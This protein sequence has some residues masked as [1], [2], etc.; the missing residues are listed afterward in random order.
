MHR[1]TDGQ[2]YG[3]PRGFTNPTSPTV[4]PRRVAPTVHGSPKRSVRASTAVA[5]L[6]RGA[7]APA[8][9]VVTVATVNSVTCVSL[10][11]LLRNRD[12]CRPP[13]RS[14]SAPAAA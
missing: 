13:L 4:H 7:V 10:A 11:A 2:A 3:C 14:P 6:V 1:A 8:T 5:P 12:T 9:G